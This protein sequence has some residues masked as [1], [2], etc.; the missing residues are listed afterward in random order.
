MPEVGYL[1]HH[2]FSHFLFLHPL[3]LVLL[4]VHFNFM[5]RLLAL[6]KFALHF[7]QFTVGRLLLFNYGAQLQSEIVF[8]T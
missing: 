4:Q 2:L 5:D 6:L 7:G 8:S 1:L 3:A